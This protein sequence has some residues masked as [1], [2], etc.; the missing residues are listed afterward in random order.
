LRRVVL[1]CGPPGSGKSTLARQ[2]AA[3]GLTLYDRDDPRWG[4]S[5]RRFRDAVAQLGHQDDARAV[6]IRTCASR[7]SRARAKAL[8]GATEV[9]VLLTDPATCRQR[10]RERG[11]TR[12]P[13]VTQL[14]AVDTWWQRY[15]PDLP[16]QPDGDHPPAMRRQERPATASR[17]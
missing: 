14:A 9:H 6:V 10:I 12:P 3:Q 2:L 11:R 15:E 1:I 5:E 16:G 17:W 13:L 8:V 7:S 4:N